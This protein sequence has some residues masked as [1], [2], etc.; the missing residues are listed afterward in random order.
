M[1]RGRAVLVAGWLGVSLTSSERVFDTAS[2]ATRD[3]LR[4]SELHGTAMRR[5]VEHGDVDA[6]VAELRQ[7]A[8]GRNDLLAQ[9]AGLIA[10]GWAATPAWFM[11]HELIAA[12]LLI[13]AGVSLDYSELTRW[14]EEGRRRGLAAR[15]PIYGSGA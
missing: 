12:G 2:V 11:G 6:A 1:T 9:V 10:G 5:A 14:T 15:R 8:D 4:M 13:E 3:N 7:L